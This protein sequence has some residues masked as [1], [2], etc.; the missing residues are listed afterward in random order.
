MCLSFPHLSPLVETI[1]MDAPLI[2]EIS[3]ILVAT[4]CQ[5][6]MTTET[7]GTEYTVPKSVKL[8]VK[9]YLKLEP[10]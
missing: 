2:F 3:L 6:E 7:D 1:S 4:F 10:V 9:F 8:Q 5:A